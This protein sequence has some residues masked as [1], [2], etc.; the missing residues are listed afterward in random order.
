MGSC[1]SKEQIYETNIYDHNISGLKIVKNKPINILYLEDAEIHYFLLKFMFHRYIDANINI[2]WKTTNE[3][4]YN[5][6][7][8]YNVDL[9]FVDRVL[10]NEIGDD[11]IL[12]IRDNNIFDLKKIIIISAINKQ[13]DI[14]KFIDMGIFY[15]KK[16]LDTEIFI[17]VMKQVFSI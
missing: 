6:I 17:S 13:E 7:E 5:Y 9:L 1:F 14:Q 16:P 8:N 2:I 10:T 4:C 11:L 3:E 12:K 15:F